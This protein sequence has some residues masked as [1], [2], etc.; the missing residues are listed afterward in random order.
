MFSS[1]PTQEDL[2]ILEAIRTAPESLH[3][4]GR[5]SVQVDPSSVASTPQFKADLER[6]RKLVNG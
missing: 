3:V 4:V 1:K 5:G 2:N 6:A